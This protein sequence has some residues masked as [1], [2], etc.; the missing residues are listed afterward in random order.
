MKLII[1]KEILLQALKNNFALIIFG[2]V[3]VF[4]SIVAAIH[5]ISGDSAQFIQLVV[6]GII[7][8]FTLGTV[9]IGTDCFILSKANKSDD[10]I[11]FL[12]N[13]NQIKN[14]VTF[15]AIVVCFVFM[16]V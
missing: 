14:R 10:K 1:S 8:Y 15:C 7:P 3:I 12:T 9:I 11:A 16:L 6:K 4:L 13:A 5:D 2:F